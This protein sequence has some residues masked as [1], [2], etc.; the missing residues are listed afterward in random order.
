MIPYALALILAM[1]SAVALGAIAWQAYSV[2]R[3][4][5]PLSTLD[6]AEVSPAI[7][8]FTSRD[9]PHCDACRY[10]RER[11]KLAS[12]AVLS[13]MARRR[14]ESRRIAPRQQGS[15]D[16]RRS[17]RDPSLSRRPGTEHLSSARP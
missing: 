8:R 12:Q 2:I 3:S 10:E 4:R 1:L 11:A 9:Q 13:K 6:R 16:P 14:Q 7:R 15:P 5:S 17:R